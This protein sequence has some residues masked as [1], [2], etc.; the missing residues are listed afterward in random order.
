M[1]NSD[2][3]DITLPKSFAHAL[4]DILSRF[5][6]PESARRI[7]LNCRDSQYYKSRKGLHPVEMQFKRSDSDERWSLVFIASFSYQDE[8]NQSLDV[9]LYFH[10]NNRWCFQPDVGATDLSHPSVLDLLYSWCAAFERHLHQHAF[11]DIR[12]TLL[13]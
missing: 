12:L 11:N 9:E 2:Y 1:L 6:T 10:L 13:R 4:S 7:S 8:S 5:I 3:N